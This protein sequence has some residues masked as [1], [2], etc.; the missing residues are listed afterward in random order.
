MLNCLFDLLL[1]TQVNS[2]DHVGMLA[3]ERGIVNKSNKN[4]FAIKHKSMSRN[5][6]LCVI[7]LKLTNA[8]LKSVEEWLHRYHFD[9]IFMKKSNLRSMA[10]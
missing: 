3:V 6:R 1:Y 7:R 9:Q 4:S 2:Y 10:S 5:F 8:I